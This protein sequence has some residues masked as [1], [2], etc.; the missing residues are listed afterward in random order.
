ML[1]FGSPGKV[2]V[3]CWAEGLCHFTVKFGWMLGISE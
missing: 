2:T 3:I 1:K